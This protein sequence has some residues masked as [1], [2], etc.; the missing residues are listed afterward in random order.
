MGASKEGAQTSSDFENFGLICGA[1]AVAV[2]ALAGLLFIFPALV[3]CFVISCSIFLTSPLGGNR[4][5]IWH[6]IFCAL[7]LW[8]ASALILG[9][10]FVS[11][12]SNPYPG[13]MFKY[14]ASTLS[15]LVAGF[16]HLLNSI[17]PKRFAVRDLSDRFIRAY[18]WLPVLIAPLVATVASRSG[19][20]NHLR[21]KL[22]AM[23]ERTKAL[24]VA[25]NWKSLN[26]RSL[27]SLV[28]T[29]VGNWTQAPDG[30]DVG[31]FKKGGVGPFQLT[32][33]QLQHHVHILGAS[34]F[35]KSVLLMILIRFRIK[36]G[37]GLFYIDL[38]AD[39][40]T[41][42]SI[43]SCCKEAN[44]LDDL[45]ILSSG[46]PTLSVPYNVVARGN[47]NEICDRIISSLNWTESFYRDQCDSV[48][49][50]V[51]LGLVAARNLSKLSFHLGDV[52]RALKDPDY[53][54][55]I[56][57]LIPD[58]PR[59]N[60]IHQALAEV[61]AYI[62]N[63]DQVK[64]LQG[65]KTQLE[66]ILLS[67]FG[68]LLSHSTSD[69]IDIFRAA[70]E[71]KIVVVFLDSRRYSVAAPALGKIIIEDLKAA[72]SQ[73]EDEVAKSD[74]KPFGVVI[75]EF[76]DLAQP[77][78]IKFQDRA[79]SSGMGIVVAHQELADL[80]SVSPE[81]P[82]RLNHL[83][84]TTFIFQTKGKDGAESIASTAGTK[85]TFK[86]TE[87]SSRGFFAIDFR[88]GEKSVRE[89]EEFLIHPNEIK[90]LVVGECAMIS[91]YPVSKSGILQI[92][93][94]VAV[95]MNRADTVAAL[96]K[97]ARRYRPLPPE[98]PREAKASAENEGCF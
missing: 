11:Q 72:S 56:N 68:H 2:A 81:F 34:G 87:R 70:R 41:L 45:M 85:L 93:P 25:K 73:L 24:W 20:L 91:K 51:L 82:V 92:A 46:H 75:D 36:K 27:A 33:K 15:D 48:L 53:I 23:S 37:H 44:R 47:A 50:K 40:E 39:F 80:M 32:I 79:R 17:L 57:Q 74:L 96:D 13:L 59:F 98:S 28:S 97:I 21:M 71:Q 6:S 62:R 69:G 94:P 90:S 88:T 16:L 31:Y 83:S 3:L 89:V 86:E 5:P 64:N 29:A 26:L 76:A 18:I 12:D 8:G 22:R 7:A 1:L 63:T 66:K 9:I 55:H 61:D 58:E 10:P 35:G 78:F 95:E 54:A 30:C 14:Q 67:E 19:K 42:Q 49:Q 84:S 65:L 52:L 77:N 38:K 60:P 43:V 4:K